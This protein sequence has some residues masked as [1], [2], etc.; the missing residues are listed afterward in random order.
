[1]ST[2]YFKAK[3]ILSLQKL[4]EGSLANSRILFLENP[5]VV[6]GF[7]ISGSLAQVLVANYAGQ[8]RICEPL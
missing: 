8:G 5:L 3:R 4:V 1:M 2:A 7:L 6:A